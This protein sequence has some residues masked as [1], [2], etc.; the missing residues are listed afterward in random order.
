[1]RAPSTLFWFGHVSS[2]FNYHSGKA[3]LSLSCTQSVGVKAP[4][5]SLLGSVVIHMRNLDRVTAA[6][7]IALSR[8]VPPDMLGTKL[9]GRMICSHE[10]GLVIRKQLR[11]EGLSPTGLSPHDTSWYLQSLSLT[12]TVTVSVECECHTIN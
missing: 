3:I 10:I 8:I 12:L 9:I 1:M 4:P 6:P 2:L 7:S 5:C 11:N